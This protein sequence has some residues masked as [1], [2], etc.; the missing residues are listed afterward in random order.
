MRAVVA[1]QV[2]Y[3]VVGDVVKEMYTKVCSL[4]LMSRSGRQRVFKVRGAFAVL[5]RIRF[6]ARNCW[7]SRGQQCEKDG[8]QKPGA[9]PTWVIVSMYGVYVQAMGAIGRRREE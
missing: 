1:L 9:R 3:L 4:L 8:S 7:V 2:S 6:E 5:L